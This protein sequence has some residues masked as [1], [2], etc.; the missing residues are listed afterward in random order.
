[1]LHYFLLVI[2]G[3]GLTTYTIAGRFIDD[4]V[5]GALRVKESWEVAHELLV[6]YLRE[7]D[8]DHTRA[9]SLANVFCR[10]GQDTF[11]AEAACRVGGLN[12]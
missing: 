1:M 8:Y 5:W 12:L 11:L 6:I 2:T 4:V 10:G 3:F 9:L 7:V